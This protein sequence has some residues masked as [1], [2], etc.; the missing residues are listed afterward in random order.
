MMIHII[1]VIILNMSV[2]RHHQLRLGAMH[3][4]IGT[5]GH[6][7]KSTV[8]RRGRFSVLLKLYFMKYINCRLW[9]FGI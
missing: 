1:A 7:K 8:V 9:K 3:M 2:R 6:D 4:T 5:M